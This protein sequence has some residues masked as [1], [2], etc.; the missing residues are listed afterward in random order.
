[1]NFN[2]CAQGIHISIKIPKTV[3][4]SWGYVSLWTKEKSEECNLRSQWGSGGI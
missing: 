2:M 4:Q 3:R 1:M